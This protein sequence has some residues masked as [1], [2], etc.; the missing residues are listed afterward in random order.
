[1]NDLFSFSIFFAAF[2]YCRGVLWL[3]CRIC[4]RNSKYARTQCPIFLYT[5]YAKKRL[6]GA[7]KFTAQKLKIHGIEIVWIVIGRRMDFHS[8]PL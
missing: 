1:M 8:I 5:C 6:E 3:K 2:V 7:L 4:R